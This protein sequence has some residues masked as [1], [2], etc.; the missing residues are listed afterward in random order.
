M[1][2][3]RFE[4]EGFVK[5]REVD[6]TIKRRMKKAKENWI[7]EQCCEIETNMT[8]NNSKRAYQ[9]VKDLT[10]VNKRESYF[11]PR[12]LRK[13]PYRR[14]RDTKPM[15]RILL[16]AVQSRDQ[17]RSISIELLSIEFA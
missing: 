9:L 2:K 15:D 11:Y 4:P 6:N 17:W 14:M 13:M 5:Y 16:R 7:G 10:T 1:R 8:K 12:P 3:K